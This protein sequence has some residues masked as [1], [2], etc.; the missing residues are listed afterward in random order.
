M[1]KKDEDVKV[2]YH[3]QN[4][5]NKVNSKLLFYRHFVVHS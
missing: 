5:V 2:Q 1:L 4:Y 3:K